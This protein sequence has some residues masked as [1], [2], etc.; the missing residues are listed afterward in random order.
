M[1]TWGLGHFESMAHFS[2]IWLISFVDESYPSSKYYYNLSIQEIST[3][4]KA[5]LI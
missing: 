5:V 4:E 1:L 2:W 3:K